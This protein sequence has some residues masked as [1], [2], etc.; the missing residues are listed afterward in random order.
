MTVVFSTHDMA[1]AEQMCD[2]VFMIYRGKKVLDGSLQSIRQRFSDDMI[3]VQFAE[4]SARL[5]GDLP[6]VIEVSD[7]G[8]EH[9]LR[10]KPDADTQALLGRLMQCG[11]IQRFERKTPTLQ[12]I[13]VRM[14]KN[15]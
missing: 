6:G 4:P 11:T 10:V 9:Q 15:G 3:H 5:N 14:A 2:S 7:L 8:Q 12:D 13:F 1:V